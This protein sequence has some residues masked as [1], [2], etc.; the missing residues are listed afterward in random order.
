MRVAIITSEEL[1]DRNL[2]SSCFELS[3]AKALQ[4]K[5]VS[6]KILSA[7]FVTPKQL[8][9]V[10]LQKLKG[11]Q[12]Y[13][14]RFR[15]WSFFRT[16]IFM[17]FSPIRVLFKKTFITSFKIDGVETVEAFYLTMQPN[18]VPSFYRLWNHHILKAYRKL[19]FNFTPDI[20]HAHSRF[21]LAGLAA[22][23]IKRS[24]FIPYVMTEHSSIYFRKKVRPFEAQLVRSV[25]HESKT[26]IAVS[27]ALAREVNKVIKTE[28]SFEIVPNILDGTFSEPVNIQPNEDCF[29]FLNVASLNQL[30]N[31]KNLINAFAILK[32]S[33]S[34]IQLNIVGNGETYD[35]LQTLIHNLNLDDFV[36][37]KGQF[38]KNDVHKIMQE[39]NVFILSSNFETF[40]VVLIEALSCGKPVISTRCGGPEE[41]VT[42]ENGLL[43]PVNDVQALADAMLQIYR[44]YSNYNADAI[45]RDCLSKYGSETIAD[46][47]ISIYDRSLSKNPIKTESTFC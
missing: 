39:C 13:H 26:N 1:N 31:H 5:G 43:V 45:R 47:L 17:A 11:Q 32:K 19:C 28:V 3:Q 20:I 10:L 41:I 35:E 14:Y 37:L 9:A 15:D 46:K 16:A 12:G 42:S 44:N 40:G 6:T 30:K 2:I 22:L 34:N 4:Q 21:L 36:F 24:R 25:M 38:E 27:K 33:Y 8:A 18:K 23:E 29:T 7:G